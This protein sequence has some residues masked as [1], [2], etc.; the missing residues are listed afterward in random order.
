MTSFA[1]TSELCH[2]TDNQ[3]IHIIN[4]SILKLAFIIEIAHHLNII[5]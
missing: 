4:L 5:I 1:K 2:Y 3:S